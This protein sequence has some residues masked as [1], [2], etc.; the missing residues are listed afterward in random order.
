MDFITII[1]LVYNRWGAMDQ[2]RV[3]RD[4]KRW[5][6]LNMDKDTYSLHFM[7]NGRQVVVKALFDREEYLVAFKA[8]FAPTPEIS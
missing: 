1:T 2:E 5:C 3:A 7:D 4:V 6:Q 8:H